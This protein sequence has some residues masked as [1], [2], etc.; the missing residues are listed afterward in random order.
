MPQH[1]TIDYQLPTSELLTGSWAPK[2]HP[3]PWRIE[4]SLSGPIPQHTPPKTLAPATIGH[5]VH[6]SKVLG[7]HQTK[8]PKSPTQPS[9][10]PV[11]DKAPTLRVQS[12]PGETRGT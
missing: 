8:N 5:P 6:H 7:A 4:A 9:N 2:A 11:S 3:C 10:F 1:I 12:Y